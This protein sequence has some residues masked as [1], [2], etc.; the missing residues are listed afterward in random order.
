MLLVRNSVLAAIRHD[1]EYKSELLW[2]SLN[3]TLSWFCL[4]YFIGHPMIRY[5]PSFIVLS[6][7]PA[8]SSLILCGDINALGIDWD[9]VSPRISCRVSSLLCDTVLNASMCQLVQTPTR[10]PISWT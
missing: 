7:L 4:V 10:I 5:L 2:E 3:V 9:L 8:A 6:S 1:L